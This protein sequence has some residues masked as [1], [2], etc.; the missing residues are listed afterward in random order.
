M[1]KLNRR[2]L[3]IPGM[4]PPSAHS[5]R[6]SIAGGAITVSLCDLTIPDCISKS[7][8][9]S[10]AETSGGGDDTVPSSVAS[11]NKELTDH[12]IL[13]PEFLQGCDSKLLN[14]KSLSGIEPQQ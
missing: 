9:S 10:I 3:Y 14:L 13:W 11:I 5:I 1:L 12:Y 7:M 2:L 8:S 6:G 4:S